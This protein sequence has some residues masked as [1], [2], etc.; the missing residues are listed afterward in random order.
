ME[1][2]TLTDWLLIAGVGMTVLT[3]VAKATPWG[4]DDK[5]VAVLF[6]V[7]DAVKA[8]KA[9]IDVLARGRKPKGNV[10]KKVDP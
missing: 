1:S 7:L 6:K 9:G 8:N 3:V 2:W 4:W 10:D 5:V